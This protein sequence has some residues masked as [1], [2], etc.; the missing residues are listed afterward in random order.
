L[1]TAQEE[2]A[3]DPAGTTITMPPATTITFPSGV[4]TPEITIETPI[5]PVATPQLPPTPP[6]EDVINAI[7]VV[8]TFGPSGTTF[9]PA[10]PVTISYNDGE[11]VGLVES[12][13]RLFLF[14]PGSGVFDI[15]IPDAADEPLAPK[16][17]I[18]RDTVNNTITFLTNSFS[19][20][21]IGASLDPVYDG[22]SDGIPDVWELE[23]GLDPL[24][25]A[26]AAQDL[27][28][29]GLSSLEEF[30]AGTD[31]NDDDS[32]NDSLPDGWEVLYGLDPARRWIDRHRQRR[33]RG[34][35]WRWL[36]QRDRVPGRTAIR[37][38][39]AARRR[40][41]RWAVQRCADRA[42]RRL[43]GGRRGL[44]APSSCLAVTSG[45]GGRGRP[46][47]TR[48][49][50]G[51]GTGRRTDAFQPQRCAKTAVAAS[52]AVR[53]VR[54]LAAENLRL[55]AGGTL[56]A[57]TRTTSRCPWHNLKVWIHLGHCL[58]EGT[59]RSRDAARMAAAR[60]APRAVAFGA[61]RG[62]WYVLII[63][64]D[65]RP[66]STPAAPLRRSQAVPVDHFAHAGHYLL[67]QY[68]GEVARDDSGYW[69]IAMSALWGYS[70]RW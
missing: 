25:P 45:A 39:P 54:R 34:S 60:C 62:G 47:Q 22:D 5:S 69:P 10:I 13:M 20:F 18:A 68:A 17:I 27:D 23:N 44:G 36:H 4:L 9:A 65:D 42:A 58:T 46:R 21:G 53:V 40:T 49:L 64:P 67:G 38:I 70:A 3:V 14:N 48:E 61:S 26:D 43:V 28:T 6:G 37:T 32:D 31:P 50:L 16:R 15:E 59:A 29:D 41:C 1:L 12:T 11:I 66:G 56:G 57:R 52:Q 51:S 30:T 19:Q 33:Q 55:E 63:F 8:R 35:R 2:V 24:N 7:P